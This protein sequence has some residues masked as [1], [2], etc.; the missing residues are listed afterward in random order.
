MM[1]KIIS[2]ALA[3]VML[4]AMSVTVFAEAVPAGN[5]TGDTTGDVVIAIKGEGGTDPV[6]KVYKVELA[7]DDLTFTYGDAVW[8]PASLSYIDGGWTTAADSN[9]DGTP[10]TIK[11]TNRSNAEVTVSAEMDVYTK[12]GVTA[13]LTNANFTLTSAEGKDNSTLPT[14]SIAVSVD[15]K[16]TTNTGFTLGTITVTLTK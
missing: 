8:D 9:G 1:K 4:L 16:P 10:A 14:A 11:V 3:V 12:N 15:G 13:S 6:A 7:W 5:I 2:I